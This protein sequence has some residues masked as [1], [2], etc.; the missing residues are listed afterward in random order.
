VRNNI[1]ISGRLPDQGNPS[2]SIWETKTN[3]P[4][5]VWRTTKEKN[6]NTV[7]DLE[8]PSQA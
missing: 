5:Y 1:E 8:L 4:D 6:L 2:V 7:K 3:E